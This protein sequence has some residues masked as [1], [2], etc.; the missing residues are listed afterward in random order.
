MK[1]TERDKKHVWH[2]FTPFL[3]NAPEIRPI[4]KAKGA[5]LYDENGS[6]YIDAVSSW[7]VS[8]H[9]HSHP[10]IISAA[11]RQMKKLDHVI[12]AGFTHEPGVELA[13]KLLS[14]LPGEFDKIFYSDNGSTAVEVAI[15]MAL[16]YWWNKGIPR[17]KIIAFRHAYHGD[18]FG[19]M[20]VGERGGFNKPY[21][22]FLFDVEHID[23]PTLENYTLV[24][25]NFTE[26]I[27]TGDVAAFIFEPLVLGSGGML[28]YDA[29]LLDHLLEIAARHD[30]I[31]IADEVMTGFY[32]TGT[33]F[34]CEQLKYK[35][36]IICLSKGLSG[37]ILPLGVTAS[38]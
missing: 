32:R 10:K 4:V 26:I 33:M 3:S 8:V 19:A 28:M 27:S 36:D 12:F 31:C 37:G 38:S 18:T 25:Q 34:A 17:K 23:I 29:Q 22:S 24:N 30:V 11:A 9:G 2:P 7:W 13:E 14:K 6:T 20:S 21:E 5:L 15:K 1:L 16:Q 35:P